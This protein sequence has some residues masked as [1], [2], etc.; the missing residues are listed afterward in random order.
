VDSLCCHFDA[1]ERIID[2][3]GRHP[4]IT[5]VNKAEAFE[6]VEVGEFRIIPPHQIRLSAYCSRALSGSD[7]KRVNPAVERHTKHRCLRSREI[8]RIRGAHKRQRR[9]MQLFVRKSVIS[10]VPRLWY[11]RIWRNFFLGKQYQCSVPAT[12]GDETPRSFW[13]SEEYPQPAE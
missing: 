12:A 7:P 8:M 13:P 2:P 5:A 9:S 3:T 1:L 10:V 6:R 11:A 4:D